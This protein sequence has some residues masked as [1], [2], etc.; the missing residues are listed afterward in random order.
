MNLRR[1]N[2]VEEIAP[3]NYQRG[4]HLWKLLEYR[5]LDIADAIVERRKGNAEASIIPAPGF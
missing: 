5:I 2:R 3:A 4:T 1:A